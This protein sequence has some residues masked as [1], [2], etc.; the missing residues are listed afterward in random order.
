M[1]R[2]ESTYHCSSLATP[3]F[4]AVSRESNMLRLAK[5]HCA[6]WIN[7]K[8]RKK[9]WHQVQHIFLDVSKGCLMK[10]HKK[11]QRNLLCLLYSVVFAPAEPQFW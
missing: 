11:M 8:E 6:K 5:H 9:F 3:K 1:G 10:I 4:S 7:D 2:P